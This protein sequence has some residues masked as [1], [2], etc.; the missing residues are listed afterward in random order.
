MNGVK[1]SEHEWSPPLPGL[2]TE[3]WHRLVSA[4]TRIFSAANFCKFPLIFSP[5]GVS[6]GT[7]GDGG[8]AETKALP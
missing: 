6:L 3:R 2:W 5:R 1:S 4:K 7:K 8:T